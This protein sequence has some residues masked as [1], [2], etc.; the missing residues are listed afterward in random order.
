MTTNRKRRRRQG[1]GSVV[2]KTGGRFYCPGKTGGRFCCLDSEAR[3]AFG[4]YIES[5]KGDKRNDVNFS[6]KELIEL[7]KE[8]LE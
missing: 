2:L 5:L 8:F 6:W 3:K 7:A 4:R 1:D